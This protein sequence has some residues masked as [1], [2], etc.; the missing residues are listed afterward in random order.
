MPLYEIMAVIAVLTGMLGTQSHAAGGTRACVCGHGEDTECCGGHARFA[1][2]SATEVREQA[3]EQST[4]LRHQIVE[5]AQGW[6]AQRT[7]RVRMR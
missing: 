5:R 1:M 2:P 3:L 4:C 6:C 7:A